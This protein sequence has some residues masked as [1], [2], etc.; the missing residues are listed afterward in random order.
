VEG[1]IPRVRKLGLP[2]GLKDGDASREL[3]S[4]N[5]HLQCQQVSLRVGIQTQR[6]VEGVNIVD[7]TIEKLYKSNLSSVMKGHANA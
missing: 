3:E 6:A 2:A 5:G 7:A 1:E 4:E